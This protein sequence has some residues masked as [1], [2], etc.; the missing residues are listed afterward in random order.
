MIG[1][2]AKIQ[3]IIFM[4]PDVLDGAFGIII[5]NKIVTIIIV[6]QLKLFEHRQQLL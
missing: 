5:V 2:L 4:V 3:G 6:Y 1:L